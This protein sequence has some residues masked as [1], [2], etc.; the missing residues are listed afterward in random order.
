MISANIFACKI[1][2]YRGNLANSPITTI[3]F[4]TRPD[5]WSSFPLLYLAFQMF[6]VNAVVIPCIIGHIGF[7][8][9]CDR[10]SVRQ[11]V[12]ESGLHLGSM[13][14]YLLLSDIFGLHVEER[15]PWREDG[16]VIYSYNLLLL[17]GPSPTDLITTFYCLI[18]DSPNY[19]GQVPVFIFTRNRVAQLYPRALGSLSSPLATRSAT[20]TEVEE[21][22]NLRPTVSRPVCFDVRHPSGTRDQ[23]LFLLEISFR[24]LRVC[25][26]V[27][28]SLTRGCVCNLLYNCFC[29][30]PKQSL[31]GRS[32]AE[33]TAMFYCL[34]W[35]SPNLEGQ[36]PVFISPRNRVAQLYLR[37]LGYLFVVSYDSQGY[38]GGIISRLH[39]DR[40]WFF[41]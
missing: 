3:R 31:L 1:S 5:W 14:T 4:E 37:A 33:L 10:R 39:T 41:F 36:V 17:S 20:E 35:D 21:E 25:Y 28:P 11:S 15:P 8:L 2:W 27:A 23:F 30:L 12:L 29:A 13:T 16:S 19:E 7:R 9:F 26:F 6:Q 34:I 32:P 18:W 22:I 40:N 24:P 38:G